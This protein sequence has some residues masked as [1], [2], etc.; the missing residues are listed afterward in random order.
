[1]NRNVKEFIKDAINQLID[2][3]KSDKKIKKFIDTHTKKIHFVPIR[4]R[5]FGGLLQSMNIQF[6]NFIEKLL[7]IIVKNESNLKI[8]DD[9]SGKRNVKLSITTKSENLIDTYITDCQNNIYN[10]NEILSRFNNLID[11]CLAYEQKTP[12]KEI[13][14]KRDIDVLFS[15]LDNKFYY[16]EVKYNDDH[17][18]G[19]YTDINRKFIKTYIGIAN[20]IGFYEKE[21]FKPILYYMTQKRMK[22]NIYIPEQE[23]IYRGEKLFDEFFNINYFDLDYIMKNIGSDEEIVNIFDKLY[24]EI[25]TNLKL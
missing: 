12:N 19:K 17:D 25:I 16:L 11:E 24:T 4:Y 13:N 2:N 21:I 3:T 14:L 1:M 23:Y 5:I 8:F 7:H 18:T 10:S 20:V 9:I 22:G 6:G 15:D